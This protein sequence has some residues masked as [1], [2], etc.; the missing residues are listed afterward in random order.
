VRRQGTCQS[1]NAA[2][3]LRYGV[4][5]ARDRNARVELNSRASRVGRL[6]KGATE[7][8]RNPVVRKSAAR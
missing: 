1:H 7:P 6:R 5:D 4:G 2:W 3:R 8:V